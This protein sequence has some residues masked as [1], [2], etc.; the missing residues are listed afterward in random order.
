VRER[1]EEFVLA[2]IGVAQAHLGRLPV[3]EVDA[4]TDAAID[5]AVRV[6][7]RFDVVL[8]VEDAA[9]G[10]DDFNLV[11]DG[12]PVRDRVLHRQLADRD[13]LAVALDAVLCAFAGRRRQRDV[14]V[15]RE[16]HQRGERAVGGNEAA[17][18][19]VRDGDRNWRAV[20]NGL[21]RPQTLAQILGTEVVENVEGTPF[22]HW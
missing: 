4:H 12:G 19:V 1:G 21:E 17:V 18:R 15:G 16:A 5:L 2:A 22:S 10:A 11:A 13:V 3:G 7:E 9:V 8:D 20:D 14:D 6:V